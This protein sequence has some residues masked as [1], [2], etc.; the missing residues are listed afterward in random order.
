MQRLIL[1][2]L[3]LALTVTPALAQEDPAGRV[4]VAY[5]KIGYGD[6]AEWIETYNQESVPVLQELVDEGVITGFGAY[7]HHTGGEHNIRQAIRGDETTDFSGF[8][9]QYLARLAQRSPERFEW[10]NRTIQ[11]HTDEIWNIGELN[12]Q[13][14]G[15]GRYFYDAVFQVN[16]ADLEEWNRM[17]DE[18]FKPLLEQGRADGLLTGW[19][20]EEHNTGGRFNWKMVTL[21]DEWDAIDDFNARLFEAVPLDHPIY[22]MIMA[23]DDVLWEAIPPPSG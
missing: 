13:E 17:W 3:A 2:L 1:A 18:T 10:S 14:G 8:W 12:V 9:D 11:A 23:H 19:V 20:E 7:M 6:L 21:F 15:G 16:F 4:Y 5:Y 22:D